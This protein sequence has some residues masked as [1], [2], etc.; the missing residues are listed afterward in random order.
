MRDE[1]LADDIQIALLMRKY[2]PEI[3]RKF[4][5]FGEASYGKWTEAGAALM[6]VKR[7][8]ERIEELEHQR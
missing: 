3:K 7:L 6:L 4:G 5:W 8:A 2:F 1:S